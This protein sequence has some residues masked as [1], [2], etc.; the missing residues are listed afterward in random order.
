M[1]IKQG[2]GS[3]VELTDHNTIIK[4]AHD[5]EQYTKLRNA[6]RFHKAL[7]P[8]GVAPQLLV[9][10]DTSIELE[11]VEDNTD[12]SDQGCFEDNLRRNAIRLLLNLKKHNVY[13][14]DLT[15]YNYIP[16]EYRLCPVDWSEARFGWENAPNKRIGMDADW[17]YPSLLAHITDHNR[18]V[19]KWLAIRE[20]IKPLRGYGTVLDLGCLYGDITAMAASEGFRVLGAD[21]GMFDKDWKG[22]ALELWPEVV[23]VERNLAEV[24][25][26][27]DFDVVLMLSSWSHFIEQHSY[28]DGLEVLDSILEGS[29]TLFF[30]NHLFGDGPGHKNIQTEEDHLALFKGLNATAIPI[31]TIPVG[32]RNFSRT[33]YKCER[34]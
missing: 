29:K 13:H 28:A 10:Y 22:I 5:H 4:T 19:R 21:N 26:H 18:I 16:Q 15:E 11:Y 1:I 8:K 31:T 33:V 9:D 27:N 20:H 14:T 3:T 17:L 24:E 34:I 23:F 12:R 2:N 7:G 25:Y 6:V 30:E 32:G